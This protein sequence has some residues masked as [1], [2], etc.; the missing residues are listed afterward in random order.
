MAASAALGHQGEYKEAM[1]YAESGIALGYEPRW[2]GVLLRTCWGVATGASKSYSQ[3]VRNI[4]VPSTPSEERLYWTS[5]ATLWAFAGKHAKVEEA[6][7]QA[8]E[9]D[10]FGFSLLY[11][12]SAPVFEQYRQETWFVD[13]LIATASIPDK[14]NSGDSIEVLKGDAP[15]N[16]EAQADETEA[17]DESE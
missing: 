13:F 3:I 5:L 15:E 2:H 7:L 10:T 4:P 16:P 17:D 8:L 11:F 6:Y 9:V 1:D 12:N 14:G